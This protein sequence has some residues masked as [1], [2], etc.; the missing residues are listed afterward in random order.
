M[1]NLVEKEI[2]HILLK[3]KNVIVNS[4]E[5]TNNISLDGYYL[6]RHLINI[7]GSQINLI[8]SEDTNFTD[9]FIENNMIKIEYMKKEEEKYYKEKIYNL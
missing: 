1:V 4:L 3:I 6:K 5:E 2:E 9:N 7:F 8:I